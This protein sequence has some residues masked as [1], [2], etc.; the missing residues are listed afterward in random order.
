MA[1][2][3]KLGG[4]IERAICDAPIADVLTVLT[5]AFVSLTLEVVR[6]GGHDA[7]GAIQIDGGPNRDITIHAP[8]G[9]V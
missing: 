4:A 9:G 5:G 8:K 1:A 6:R 2:L 7:S 3:D